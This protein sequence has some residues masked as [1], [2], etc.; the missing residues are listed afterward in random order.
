MSLELNLAANASAAS[1]PIQGDNVQQPLTRNQQFALLSAAIYVSAGILGFFV[2]GTD[3][4]TADTNDKLIILGL[5]PLHN[6]V[7]L[8]LGGTWLAAAASRRLAPVVNIALGAG[9]LA[10]FALGVAGG[11][12]FLNIDNAAEPDNYL[13]L[14]YGVASIAVGRLD[15]PARAVHATRAS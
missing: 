14:V 15:L 2:T 4:F 6:I 5:N 11:A 12:Q 10:A 9:L 8:V 7:H 13:H 1:A 3:G